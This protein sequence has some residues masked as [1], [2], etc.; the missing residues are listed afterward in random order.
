MSEQLSTSAMGGLLSLNISVMPSGAATTGAVPNLGGFGA[1]LNQQGVNGQAGISDSGAVLPPN[2]FVLPQGDAA[3]TLTDQELM[4]QRLLYIANMLEQ[5]KQAGSGGLPETISGELARAL[6]EYGDQQPVLSETPK[7]EAAGDSPV[8]ETELPDTTVLVAEAA[9]T[10]VS[11][12]AEQT[13]VITT[14][15]VAETDEIS[16]SV[17]DNITVTAKDASEVAPQNL[18]QASLNSSGVTNQTSVQAIDGAVAETS[19]SVKT[20]VEVASAAPQSTPVQTKT[21]NSAA[22]ATTTPVVTDVTKD[23]APL[24]G[25]QQNTAT[26]ETQRSAAVDPRQSQVLT[27]T[28]RQ[29]HVQPDVAKRNVTATATDNVEDAEKI[30]AEPVRRQ[31]SD[32]APVLANKFAPEVSGKAEQRSIISAPVVVPQGG[33]Q[34]VESM[35]ELSQQLIA[36]VAGGEKV[37]EVVQPQRVDGSYINATTE[38]TQGAAQPSAAQKQ[39]SEAQNLMMPQQVKLNTPAWNNALGERAVMLAAQ[40]SRVAEIKLDPPELGSLSVR[41]QVNQDQVSINFTS[42]HAHVRDAVEQSLPRLREMFAEQG[43]ALQDSSVSDQSSR[44]SGEQLADGRHGGGTGG[45]SEEG[46]LA[47]NLNQTDQKGRPISLVDYYA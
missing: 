38:V 20:N 41:V 21:E 36:K 32:S 5:Q 30:K 8:N 3:E 17:R 18:P 40:N 7:Q 42:P 29:P 13:A 16:Q 23:A 15:P 31:I 44:E 14:P 10:R 25:N 47:E 22:A 19:G 4:Q 1:L 39:V 43:L 27:D 46:D 35:L 26:V 24:T 9:D 11:P 12:V 37:A 2:G 6:R 33:A 34:K 28:P 45:D